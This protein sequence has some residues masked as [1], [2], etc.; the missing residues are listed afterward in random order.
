[1]NTYN[2]AL[3]TVDDVQKLR[4]A[5]CSG[6]MISATPYA[7]LPADVSDALWAEITSTENPWIVPDGFTR[8]SGAFYLMPRPEPIVVDAKPRKR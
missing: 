8:N 4:S 6:G 5:Y 3:D 1:M 7:I 2:V